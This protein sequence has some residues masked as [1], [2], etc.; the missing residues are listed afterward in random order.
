MNQTWK[1]YY[2]V[3]GY[4]HLKA[5]ETGIIRQSAE[6]WCIGKSIHSVLSYYR[7][8]EYSVKDLSDG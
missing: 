6:G 2:L 7:K 4:N 1:F 5:D 3:G 8:M